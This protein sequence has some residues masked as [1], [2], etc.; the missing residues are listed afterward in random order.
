MISTPI[1]SSPP[2]RPFLVRRALSGAVSPFTVGR[3]LAGRY[4]GTVGSILTN[5]NPCPG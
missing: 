3:I 5:S 1:L 2:A 4:G